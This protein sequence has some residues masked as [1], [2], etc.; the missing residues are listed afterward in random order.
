VE[1]EQ[2]VAFYFVLK[3]IPRFINYA[4]EEYYFLGFFY[5]IIALMGL[6][7]LFL[8]YKVRDPAHIYY[9]LYIITIGLLFMTMDGTAFQFL[10]PS[11]PEYNKYPSS[12]ASLFMV[13]SALLYARSFLSSIKKVLLNSIIFAAITLK[14]SIF[15]YRFFYSPYDLWDPFLDWEILL[16]PLA[17]GIIALYNGYKPARYYVAAFTFVSAG[18]LTYALMFQGL[19]P[20]NVITVYSLNY[21]EIMEI[22]LLS[23]ALA[24]RVR[25]FK[26]EKEKAQEERLQ[27]LI[28]KESLQREV[29][30]QL[31]INEE[32]KDKVNRELE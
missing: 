31:K 29:I 25:T 15:F 5:G 24:H 32:L 12:I 2:F 1:S 9:V 13:V 18:F 10:W 26:M 8:Y 14:V 17:L 30:S 22:I 4:L 19:I 11:Y 3:S 23:L 7:N 16:A 28:L 6:L 20:A 21:A 27:E